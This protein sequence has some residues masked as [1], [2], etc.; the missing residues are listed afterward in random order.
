[1]MGG[2]REFIGYDRA[3]AMLPDGDY[4][5]TFRQAGPCLIGADVEREKLLLIMLALAPTIELTGPI[6]RG[7]G[8]GMVLADDVGFLFIKTKE[9]P[10]ECSGCGDVASAS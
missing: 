5:H 3:V 8:H 1:M 4:V 7:M 2:P 9:E 6:M 10:E